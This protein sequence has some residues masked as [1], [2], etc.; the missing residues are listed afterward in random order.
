MCKYSSLKGIK[1]NLVVDNTCFLMKSLLD[2]ELVIYY[3][4]DKNYQVGDL[5]RFADNTPVYS[6][7]LKHCEIRK[8]YKDFILN[9]NSSFGDN[10]PFKEYMMALANKLERLQLA[11]TKAKQGEV[12]DASLIPCNLRVLNTNK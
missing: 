2:S 12:I 1:R 3:P 10:K 7:V 5:T 8:N 11:I 9:H 4:P 6:T